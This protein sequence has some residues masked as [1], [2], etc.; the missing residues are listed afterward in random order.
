MSDIII[1][2]KR[3][4]ALEAYFKAEFGSV[5]QRLFSS[6]GRAEIVGNHTDHNRGKVLV[7]AI[8]CDILCFVSPRADGIIDIRAEAFSP[9]H[10]PV[11]DLNSRER[12]KGRSVSL[13]RGVCYYFAS[14]GYPIG[15]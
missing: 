14:H 6:P 5:P 8:S 1:E 15:G 3:L 13:A 2:K 7:S 12:E 4:D 10:F 9:V 11:T